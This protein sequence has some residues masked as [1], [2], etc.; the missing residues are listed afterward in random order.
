MNTRY[1]VWRNLLCHGKPVVAKLQVE[2]NC[3]QKLAYTAV[4]GYV[5]CKQLL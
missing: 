5:R 1:Q 2:L 4:P 3:H